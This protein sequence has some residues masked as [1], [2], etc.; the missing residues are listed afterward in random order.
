[1]DEA[2]EKLRAL[3]YEFGNSDDPDKIKLGANLMVISGLI[4]LGKLNE[5]SQAM[6]A[7]AEAEIK[8][9]TKWLNKNS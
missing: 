9:L 5:L 4:K 2:L 1:M 8:E 3:A 6:Q 7:I